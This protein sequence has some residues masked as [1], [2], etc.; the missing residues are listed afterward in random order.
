MT[1]TN[2]AQE[3]GVED[4]IAIN[5]GRAATYGFL[6]Q[7]YREECSQ[8]LID[9]LHGLHYRVSTGNENMDRG[10][11]LIATWLSGLWED[12]AT[13][14]SADFSRTFFGHG[15]SGHSA[16]YPFESVYASE[17][18]LLMQG[19]R[20]EILALYRAEGLDKQDSWKE[21]ED[22]IALEMEYMQVLINRTVEA[23]RDGRDDDA[24]HYV[25]KQYNFVEDHLGAWAPLLTEQMR[26][27]C[28]TKFYEGLAYMTDG[29][30]EVDVEL[31]E[32]MLSAGDDEAAEAAF[33][34]DEAA[35]E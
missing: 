22:H 16:A 25:K 10:H 7:L 18:R 28:H 14:L 13:E 32:D 12:S 30:L 5:E 17:K 35:A 29:F 31:M 33:D 26:G 6:A 20:D 24:F 9:E 34:A 27:F 23:L 15:Y 19:A 21:G 11:K 1:E 8:E 3:M 2:A 4:L